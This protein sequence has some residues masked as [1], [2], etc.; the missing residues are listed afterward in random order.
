M[1]D[2]IVFLGGFSFGAIVVLALVL[3]WPQFVFLRRMDDQ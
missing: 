3:R 1:H 2:A